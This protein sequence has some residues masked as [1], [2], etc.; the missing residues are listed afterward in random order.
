MHNCLVS[1]VGGGGPVQVPGVH[2]CRLV[3]VAEIMVLESPGL[4][5]FTYS[6]TLWIRNVSRANMENAGGRRKVTWQF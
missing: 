4:A 3:I 5:V 1:R 2:I 6:G